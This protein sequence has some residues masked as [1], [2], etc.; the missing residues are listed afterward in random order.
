MDETLYLGI[1]GGGSKCHAVLYRADEGIIGSGIAG[2]ANPLQ[3]YERALLSI[4]EAATAAACD[5]GLPSNAVSSMVTGIG[6]AGL[7][8]GGQLERMAR[9]RHPFACVRFATDLEI[10]CLGAHDGGDGA[11]V[12]AGTGSSG[13]VRVGDHVR[14]IGGTGFPAGDVG[15]GA[16]LGLKALMAVFEAA[17]ELASE[18]SL[19]GRIEAHFGIRGDAI[20]ERIAGAPT[21]VYAELAP[22][23]FAAA[24][25]GDEVATTLVR[26]GAMYLCR[27]VRKLLESKPPRVS[28]IGGLAPSISEWMEEDV[29]AC[30][31]PPIESPAMGAV[32]LALAET[33]EERTARRLAGRS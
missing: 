12:I 14:I 21:S 3:G 30:L 26:E 32:L 13:Y 24:R 15:S 18:T 8:L 4:A 9:W 28:L 22:L 5:A 25:A 23:V 10:A 29:R 16:W 27:M 20:A 17:D 19:T 7:N 1:D 31:A 33:R 11:V 6:L 2:P